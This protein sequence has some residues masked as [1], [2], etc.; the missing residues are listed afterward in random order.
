MEQI[1]NHYDFDQSVG[2]LVQG[3]A[4]GVT[5]GHLN[6]FGLRIKLDQIRIFFR[7]GKFDVFED[8][9]SKL[10]TNILDDEVR[11]IS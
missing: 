11:I 2:N 8:T 4:K 6:V 5:F 7:T 3:M 10:H 1:A 9:E